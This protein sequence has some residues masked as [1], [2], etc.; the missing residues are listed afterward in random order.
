VDPSSWEGHPSV[1]GRYDG[2]PYFSTSIA[3]SLT[4]DSATRQVMD[5]DRQSKLLRMKA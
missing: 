5:P 1:A 4:F 2:T 3:G